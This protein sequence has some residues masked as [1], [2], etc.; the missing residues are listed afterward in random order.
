[1]GLVPS[2]ISACDIATMPFPDLPHYRHCMSPLKMFEY[3]AVGRP[4]LASDLPTIRDVLSEETA[5]FYTP[6]D[7]DDFLRLCREIADHPHRA[8]DRAHRA[9]MLVES[10]TW[11]VRMKRILERFSAL[12]AR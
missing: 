10:H 5:W 12:I 6:S 2:A 7:V 4:I 11:N 1:M 3:M 8:S 9:R